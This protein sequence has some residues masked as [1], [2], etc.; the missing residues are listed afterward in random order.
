MPTGDDKKLRLTPSIR[1]ERSQSA[2]P[3]PLRP[4]S[5]AS[6][7]NP[8]ASSDN[9]LNISPGPSSRH[10]R[11]T[12]KMAQ[13][14]IDIAVRKFT[15]TT[16]RVSQFEANIHTP[17]TPETTRLSPHLCQVRR[18]Q[19]RALWEKVEKDYDSCSELLAA[20]VEPSDIGLT[21]Q[22]K[23]EYCFSVYEKC[24]ANL[25][26]L[27]EKATS[28][29][30]QAS[31]TIQPSIST[32]CRLPPVDTE[33]FAGDYLRWPTFRDLFTAIYIQN[34]RLTPWDC[35]LVFMASSKSHFLCGSN[36]YIIRPKFQPGRNW[37]IS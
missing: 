12:T 16:D 29:S 14:A 33:V 26:E 3:R 31:A 34:S 23:Y 18:D 19:I 9:S 28:Q 4:K 10:T 36:P 25:Q 20:S 35:L 37:I 6:V 32:G 27:I 1:L 5:R 11:S 30:S 21:L 24:V 7:S 8:R 17:G 15:A 22:S 2:S 13:A